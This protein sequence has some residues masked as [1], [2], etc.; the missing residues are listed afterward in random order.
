MKNIVWIVSA[1]FVTGCGAK[2]E[3]EIK[4]EQPAST[5]ETTVQLTDTQVAIAGVVTGTIEKKDIASIL[6]VNGRIDVPPQNIVS[7][8]VPLGGYLRSSNL[9][10]GMHVNKGQTLALMED[11]Q[12]IQLQQDYLTAKAK[13]IYAEQE[14][15]RQKELNASKASSDKVFQQAQAELSSQ[16]I[17]VQ[18]LAE[19]LR[20]IHINPDRLT[21]TNLSRNVA[22]PSPISGFV[23][24]VNVNIGKYVNPADALFEIVNPADI[25]LALDVF[26]KDV[27]KL[28]IGQTLVAYTNTDR[29]KKY[30]CEII[31]ISKDMSANKSFEVHCH[32]EKY[33]KDLLP[34]MFMTAEIQV[35]SK[36]SY[37]LPSDAL[38]NFQKRHYVFIEKAKN[39]FE[40]VEVQPGDS[41]D[42]FTAIT[43]ESADKLIG[44]KVTMKGAYNLLMALKN[45]R[46]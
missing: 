41:E 25:H 29:D 23:S 22:I 13:L 12:Y 30:P 2:N 35:R 20:L 44:K 7:I 32:F 17:L 46:E 38:V 10:P 26:E 45:A 11:P 27:N 24:K 6:K 36:N 28:F 4:N 37:V 39:T 16:Q 9:L 14:Y 18:S 21:A 1:M 31:L 8:S 42:S 5:N 19:K 40:V 3:G 33:D 15:K 34:G 43:D